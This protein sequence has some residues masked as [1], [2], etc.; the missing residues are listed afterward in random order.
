MGSNEFSSRLLDATI[1]IRK[2]LEGELN[3]SSFIG[4]YS[5]FYYFEALDGHEDSSALGVD[6][7]EKYQALIELHRRMQEEVINKV[8]LSHEFTREQLDAAGLV[9]ELS[10]KDRAWRIC[11]ECGMA[12]FIKSLDGGMV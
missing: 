10:A 8:S 6:I 2:F 3:L 5:N 9:D 12:A 1:L 11:A 7:R 4:E